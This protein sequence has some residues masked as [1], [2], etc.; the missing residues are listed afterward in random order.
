M[1]I[2]ELI[3]GVPIYSCCTECVTSSFFPPCRHYSRCWG[4]GLEDSVFIL[5]W[6]FWRLWLYWQ[7]PC[8][9]FTQVHAPLQ[10]HA[11]LVSPGLS[12]VSLF[13]SFFSSFKLIELVKPVLSLQAR[14]CAGPDQWKACPQTCGQTGRCLSWAQ[15]HGAAVQHRNTLYLKSIQIENSY[16]HNNLVLPF[17]FFVFIK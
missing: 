17:L 12:S 15:S 6:G 3:S 16:F 14:G 13:F 2:L 8:H 4:E 9:H 5:L 11:Q 1:G 10:D 7:S